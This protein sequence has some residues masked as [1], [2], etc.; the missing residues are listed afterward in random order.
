MPA[1]RS[2]SR[3]YEDRRHEDRPRLSPLALRRRA[4]GGH[5]RHGVPPAGEAPGRLR[6]RRHGD[7][8]RRGAGARASTARW[9]TPNTPRRSGRSRS[10]SSAAIPTRW[11]KPRSRPG[12]RR[13]HR[14]RQHGLP[15]AEDREAQRRLQPDA[16]ARARGLGHRR[17]GKAV[18][19]PVTVKMRAGWNERRDQRA[20]AREDGRGCG[21]RGRGRPRPDGGAVVLGSVRLEPDLRGSPRASDPGA[22]GAAIASS[23]G[24][25]SSVS[26]PTGVSGVLVGRGVLRNPWILAQARDLAEWA[27]ARAPSRPKS[28]ASS[29]STTWTCCCTSAS[30]KRRAS[31]TRRARRADRRA[32]DRPRTRAVG[33]QQGAR[34]RHVVHEGVRERL[35]PAHG[36]QPVR[37][38]GRAPRD[39]SRTF[40]FEGRRHHAGRSRPRASHAV[41]AASSRAAPAA[42][43]TPRAARAQASRSSADR[44]AAT[45]RAAS[46]CSA[47]R[48]CQSRSAAI[49]RNRCSVEAR[50]QRPRT[51]APPGTPARAT[52]RPPRRTAAAA[53]R[54][55]RPARSAG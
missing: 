38:A 25:S 6:T 22:S 13:R 19:I 4:H 5:D 41:P 32:P 16:R 48:R 29:C 50:R 17:D 37:V 43:R 53:G 31:G 2:C 34:A 36:D 28:A 55:A 33:D 30:T 7:G 14:R 21:R 47:G 51:A 42:T 39:D 45:A 40:F 12:P 20:D 49:T 8:E 27:R 11:R 10:R 9:S 46:P 44:P 18:S 35:A 26:R 54:R 15:G 3:A 24:R 23:R 1:A 52:A